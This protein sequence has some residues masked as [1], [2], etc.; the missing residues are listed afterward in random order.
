MI[1]CIRL[2]TN[3]QESSVFEEGYLALPG[4]HEGDAIGQAFAAASVSFRETLPSGTLDWHTAPAHQLVLTL[5][6]TLEFRTRQG[7]TFVIRPGDVL[8]AEDTT[9]SGHRWR[10][11]GDEPWRRAYVILP[12][13]MEAGFTPRA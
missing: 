7:E 12:A 2:S 8:L 3:N 13:G 5:G 10:L 9:G 6:G 4:G 1:R 11:I